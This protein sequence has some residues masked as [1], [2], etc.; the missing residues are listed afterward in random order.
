MKIALLLSGGTGTRMGLDIPK[1]Y[2]E[3]GGHRVI[4]YALK[5]LWN[6]QEIDAI[7]IVVADTW[8]DT[9]MEEVNVLKSENQNK[10][11]KPVYF[12]L[13]GQTRQLSIYNGLLDMEAYAEKDSYVF[14]HDAARPMLTQQMIVD[15]FQ[16]V[17]GH[18]GL[19]P[20]LP[21]KDTVYMSKDG[22][23]VTSLLT[24][25]EVYAGQAPEIFRL[26]SYILA[27]RALLPEEILKINGSTEP[28]IL[29][30]LD[31]AMIPGEESNYKITT[32]E[33]LNRFS[34]YL[35]KKTEE[36]G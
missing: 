25:S 28:A 15:Y 34:Q 14:I 3:V 24:R 35:K 5:Q 27:N 7:Q 26:H 1:Q 17:L 21:M 36:K 2:V 32:M 30:G 29:A 6:S 20:A 11:A 33:D 23:I 10:P 9:V 19:M 12:S 13:P 4:Y 18:D 16:A 8:K 31:I 22:K